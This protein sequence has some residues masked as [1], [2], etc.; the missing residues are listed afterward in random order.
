MEQYKKELEYEKAVDSFREEVKRLDI[1]NSRLCEADYYSR[2]DKFF[3]KN[4]KFKKGYILSLI[5]PEILMG[6]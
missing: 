4:L 2:C 1:S 6:C 3:R 5:N